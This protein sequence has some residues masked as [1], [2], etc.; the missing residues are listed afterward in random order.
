MRFNELKFILI[1]SFM[2]TGIL[3]IVLLFFTKGVTDD[4]MT[5]NYLTFIYVVMVMNILF[6]LY[7]IK[8]R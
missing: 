6:N 1:W 4:V 8:N 7:L 3:F 5:I 2:C